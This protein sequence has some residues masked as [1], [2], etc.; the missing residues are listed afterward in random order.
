[1]PQPGPAAGVTFA[2]WGSRAMPAGSRVRV[3][4]PAH[5]AR[6][7]GRSGAPASD[8]MVHIERWP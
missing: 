1:M 6:R 4:I 3:R 5:R 8:A 7:R 2:S